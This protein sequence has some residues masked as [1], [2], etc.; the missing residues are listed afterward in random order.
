ME[1]AAH[2]GSALEVPA[3][4][5]AAGTFQARGIAAAGSV[6]LVVIRRTGARIARALLLNVAFATTR[7]AY[8]VRRGELAAVAAAV[9]GIVA[10]GAVLELACLGIAAFVVST[11]LFTP[12]VAVF[13]VFDNTVPALAARDGSDTAVRRETR[14]LDTVA[15]HGRADVSNRTG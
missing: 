5:L 4:A 11:R 1:E 9:V 13:S 3:G 14:A 2:Y 8:S 6:V 15:A 12:T 7:T 10:D